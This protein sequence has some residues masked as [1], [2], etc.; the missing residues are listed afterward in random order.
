MKGVAGTIYQRTLRF[1]SYSDQIALMK[2]HQAM[3]DF[4]YAESDVATRLLVNC[5]LARRAGAQAIAKE[6]PEVVPEL[7]DVDRELVAKYCWETN[8][9]Y[10]AVKLMLDVGFL[11]AHPE[12]SHGYTPLHIFE[13]RIVELGAGWKQKRMPPPLIDDSDRVWSPFLLRR[14]P[15]GRRAPTSGWPISFTSCAA[16]VDSAAF[17]EPSGHTTRF[18]NCSTADGLFGPENPWYINRSDEVARPIPPRGLGARHPGVMALI[19]KR[20][21]W[22]SANC[23]RRCSS[24][25]VACARPWLPPQAPMTVRSPIPS[26]WSRLQTRPPG[27]LQSTTFSSQKVF[28]VPP[29]RPMESKSFLPVILLAAPICGK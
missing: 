16:S 19:G 5:V 10:D 26:R 13:I 27:L 12:H 2:G 18:D 8:T 3:F 17:R 4:L 20:L 7:P 6:H 28:S 23:W 29:G 15:E 21:V 11:V 24:F 25:V 22:E 14:S 1:N 9:N